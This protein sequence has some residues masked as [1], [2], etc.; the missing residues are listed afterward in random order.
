MPLST[1]AQSIYLLHTILMSGGIVKVPKRCWIKS[2]DEMLERL[3]ID[4][5]AAHQHFMSAPKKELNLVGD[6]CLQC[7]NL[8]FEV[9]VSNFRQLLSCKEFSTQWLKFMSVLALNLKLV[10]RSIPLHDETVEMIGALLRLLRPLPVAASISCLES[11]TTGSSTSTSEGTQGTDVSPARV[12]PMT[13]STNRILPETVSM[14]SFEEDNL[15]RE[16]WRVLKQINSNIPQL[17]DSKHPKIVAD[18]T[19]LTKNSIPSL[20]STPK[21][22]SNGVGGMDAESDTGEVVL[23]SEKKKSSRGLLGALGF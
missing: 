22:I 13:P 15:L 9:M 20:S 3:P 14:E 23:M 18:L 1:S 17:L 10:N 11:P 16:S 4:L 19:N 21:N 7:C 6:V 8:L 5:K 2:I 12:E